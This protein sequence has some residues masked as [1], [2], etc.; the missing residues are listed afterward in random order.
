MDNTAARIIT[1]MDRSVDP[2]H[3]FFQFSCGGWIEKNPIPDDKPSIS[4]FR[5]LEDE[6]AHNLHAILRE[7]LTNQSTIGERNMKNFFDSCLDLEQLDKLGLEPL[8]NI[9]NEFGGWPIIND[10]WREDDVQLTELDP[11]VSLLPK[12]MYLDPN[13]NQSM[14]VYRAVFEKVVSQF[15]PKFNLSDIQDVI[16]FETAHANIYPS[17]EHKRSYRTKNFYSNF[18][19]LTSLFGEVFDF[20]YV[21]Q[22]LFQFADVEVYDNET[23]T[24]VNLQYFEQLVELLKKTPKRTVVNTLLWDLVSRAIFWLPQNLIKIGY[25]WHKVYY[26]VNKEKPRWNY[27]VTSTNDNFVMTLGRLY[28]ENH[29]DSKS[30]EYALELL[31]VIRESFKELIDDADWMRQETKVKAKEKVDSMKENI[32]YP[33][34]LFNET[35]RQEEVKELSLRSDRLF[36][37][38]HDLMQSHLLKNYKLLRMK[39]DKNRW[40]SPI[41][42]INA[43]YNGPKNQITFPA[44]ILQSPFYHEFNPRY[45]NFGGIGMVIGHELTHGFDDKEQT[46]QQSEFFDKLLHIYLELASSKRKEYD[47]DGNVREWWTV[48]DNT[49]FHHKTKCMVDQYSKYYFDGFNETL[50]GNLTQGENIADNGGLRQAFLAYKKWSSKHGEEPMLPGLPYNPHQL[51]FINFGQIWCGTEKPEHARHTS[52]VGK[53][54]PGKYRVIGTLV[55]MWEFAETFNCPLNSP[56]NPANKC[57]VWK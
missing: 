45:L 34:Y 52:Q 31:E 30:K 42:M 35:L 38:I 5:I 54:A 33:D 22:N 12:R 8:M 53:H 11:G 26:G 19:N 32:G 49:N 36:Q 18:D 3:D 51:L 21:V 20:K 15:T 6:L 27:C 1:S 39:T 17:E 43:F 24:V 56:M 14:Q 44:G 13:F 23:I 7:P 16:D 25:E 50:N 55:N 29:F 9:I 57:K 2:C 41:G 28:V 47:K 46:A 48:D 37:N 40:A 4:T 10:T